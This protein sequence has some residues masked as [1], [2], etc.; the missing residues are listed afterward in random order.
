M[1]A[2]TPK[3]SAVT[4]GK[5]RTTTATN[6]SCYVSSGDSA[7]VCGD[8]GGD[9]GCSGRYESGDGGGDRSTTRVRD[10]RG[11]DTGG[12]GGTDISGAEGMAKATAALVPPAAAPI[13]TVPAAAGISATICA[14]GS[15]GGHCT[16]NGTTTRIRGGRG[17]EPAARAVADPPVVS[18]A[19][20]AAVSPETVSAELRKEHEQKKMR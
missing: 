16:G 14:G 4:K 18:A 13:A 17:G 12:G 5:V 9:G 15:N 1:W 19:T 6:C 10:G 2:R 8:T 11:G 3:A 20:G 7:N